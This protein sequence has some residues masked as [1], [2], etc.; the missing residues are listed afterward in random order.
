LKTSSKITAWLQILRLPNIFTAVADVTMGYLVARRELDPPLH[1]GLLVAASC[2]LYLSGMVLND[3]FDAEV[4]AVEQPGRPI[5]SGRISRSSA[6]MVGWTMLCG[7]ILV[8]WIATLVANDWRPG[9]IA[10]VLAAIILLY[11]GLLKH[12]C[13][14]PLLMGEC[15]FLNVLLGMSLM[16][17]P[18]GKAELLIAAGIGIYAM[19]VTMFARTDAHVSSRVRLSVGF[20]VLLAGMALVAGTPSLS[21]F[22]PPLEVATG[23]WYLLWTALALITARRCI[24]AIFEPSPQRVQA[25][26]RHCV[27]SI[28]VLDAAICIG[29]AS[30][31]WGFIMLFFLVPTLLLTLWLNAT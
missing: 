22:R 14:G 3:V 2:L 19:G 30:P 6:A 15:R 16:I 11:D 1:F 12:S 25:A 17:V 23:G 31:Y 13:F 29:Y 24:M 20:V 4:D 10:T 7:G 8:G 27:R 9:V 26:V 21:Y 18:W 5:P 28:I